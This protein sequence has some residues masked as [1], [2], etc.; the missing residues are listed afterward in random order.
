MRTKMYTI[1]SGSYDGHV[2][3]C[4]MDSREEAEALCEKLNA[5]RP[6]REHENMNDDFRVGE[7]WKVDGYDD[8]TVDLTFAVEL[9]RWGDELERRGY[10]W[11]ILPYGDDVPG[12]TQGDEVEIELHESGGLTAISPLSYEHALEGGRKTL[13]A[14]HPTDP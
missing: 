11:G 9:N 6:R 1:E 3:H 14:Q 4:I 5:I 7:M 12:N 13:A 2:T 10:L 8:L